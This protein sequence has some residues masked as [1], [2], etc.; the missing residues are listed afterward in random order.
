M[1][2]DDF[3]VE[4]AFEDDITTSVINE[5]ACTASIIV[6]EDCVLAGIDESR[7]LFS[8]QGIKVLFSRKDGELCSEGEE[9]M[10]IEGS[11]KIMFPVVRA[12]LNLLGRM[13]GVASMCAKAE[14]IASRYGVKTAVTRKTMPGLRFYDKKAASIGG[15]WGHR[16]DLSDMFL[17][18]KTHLSY[19]DGIGE[20]VKKARAFDKTK[21]IDVEVTSLEEALEAARAGADIVMLDNFS[22]LEA[23]KAI[24]ALREFDIKIEVSGGIDLDTL[25]AYARLKPDLISMGC[26]TKSVD[27]IDFSLRIKE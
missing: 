27:S 6:N 15:S 20:A 9:V 2:L 11:N 24:S 21:K 7:E 23:K 3:L 12:A 22:V 4:D 8:S 17:F 26:L 14:K 18:K 10:S 16:R 25:E 5:S 1:S 13:S 19:L